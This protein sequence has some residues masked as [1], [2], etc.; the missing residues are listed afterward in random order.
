MFK[1][2]DSATVDS[3]DD[4]DEMDYLKV[5]SGV[6][7]CNMHNLEKY[8]VLLIGGLISLPFHNVASP[9]LEGR[10]HMTQKVTSDNGC[11]VKYC[12]HG[13]RRSY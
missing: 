10:Y 6:E 3:S 8:C 9:N 11:Y 7:R 13:Y 4:E 1:T 2:Y 12:N 5:R